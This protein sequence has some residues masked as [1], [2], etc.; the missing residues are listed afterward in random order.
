MYFPISSTLIEYLILAIVNKEDSYGYE[1]SQI[2]KLFVNIKES[3]FYTIL[4]KFE[5]SV[6]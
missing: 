2:I 3:I 5:K 4:K 1:I 6:I